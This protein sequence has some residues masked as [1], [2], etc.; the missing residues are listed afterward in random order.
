MYFIHFKGIYN[1]IHI[2]RI[3]EYVLT[4]STNLII[5][6]FVSAILFVY[7][8]C[9]AFFLLLFICNKNKNNNIMLV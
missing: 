7:R 4:T 2:L 1:K 6:I 9:L 8:F 5:V 3:F